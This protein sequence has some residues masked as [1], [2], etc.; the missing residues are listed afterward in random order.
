MEALFLKIL[1]MSISAGWL[2][3]AVVVLR[4]L[5]QKAPKYIRCILWGLVALRLICPFTVESVLSLIPSAET[6]PEEFLYAARPAIDSGIQ[7]FNSVVNPIVSEVLAPEPLASAN[8]T[9]IL[10]FIVAR[11]WV[12]GIAAMLLYALISYLRLRFRVRISLPLQHRVFLC[13]GIDTP[14]ILGI[15]RP[16]IYL[17]SAMD[18]EQQEFVIAHEQAH[19]R[20][21]DHWWK[22][23]GFALLAVYWFNPL[24]W[25]AYILL[26]RDIELACD[27]RVIREMDCESKKAYSEALLRCSLPR[28]SIAACPLAFG[29]VGI[30]SRIRAVLHYKKPA[31]W[32]IILAFLACVAVSVFFLTDPLSE[33]QLPEQESTSDLPGLSLVMR[34]AELSGNA[35]YITVD[36]VNR[37]S[38]TVDFGEFFNLQYKDGGEW[39]EIDL[40][41]NRVFTTIGYMI[42]PGQSFEQIYRLSHFDLSRPGT[43]RLSA[44]CSVQKGNKREEYTALLE[45]W[46]PLGIKPRQYQPVEMIYSNGSFSFVMEAE[47]APYYRVDGGILYA[48]QRDALEWERIGELHQVK[49]EKAAFDQRFTNQVWEGGNSAAKLRRN[50]KAMWEL[51]ADGNFYMLLEQKDGTVYLG[52]GNEL[53]NSVGVRWLFLLEE[54]SETIIGG[55]DGPT[56][57][58]LDSAYLLAEAIDAAILDHSQSAE[59]DGLIHTAAFESIGSISA[60]STPKAAYEGYMDEITIGVMVMHRTYRVEKGLPVSVGTK[61]IPAV[62]RFHVNAAGDYTLQEYFESDDAAEIQAKFPAEINKELLDAWYYQKALESACYEMA[63]E[64]LSGVKV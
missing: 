63:V 32:L 7:S 3:L 45:F 14:F 1:N 12:I 11:L 39:V 17:P 38:E 6:L 56:S 58:A 20:R 57:V 8:P 49:L 53:N 64:Q 54:Y 29:E 35:P 4:F 50:N 46:L 34:D 44:E 36:W 10:S 62:L 47:N 15:L 60:K 23:L 18:G 2:V 30:K 48:R 5:L 19:L 9:Q 51:R 41:E 27:E 13:D 28:R 55:A 37:S 24:M 59:P 61:L 16:R 25:V 22:P 26:C 40:S 42:R 21:K 33:K 43:Y 52:I 31:F